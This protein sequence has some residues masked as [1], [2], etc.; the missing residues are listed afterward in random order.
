MTSEKNHSIKYLFFS[1]FRIFVKVK[2][3]GFMELPIFAENNEYMRKL[4]IVLAG[5]LLFTAVSCVRH[6]PAKPDEPAKP[7]EHR[8]IRE[9]NYYYCPTG[10]LYL[11][12]GYYRIIRRYYNYEY[13]DSNIFETIYYK[14]PI[15]IR[16]RL[17]EYGDTISIT[18]ID[19]TNY[20]RREE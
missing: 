2:F 1:L 16:A 9:E 13:K 6:K 10:D 8:M 5:I 11:H 18:Y 4:G 17:N 19:L 15:A 14:F 3:G 20:P 7:I 12:H